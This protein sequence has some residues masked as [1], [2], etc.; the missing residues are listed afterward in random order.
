MFGIQSENDTYIGGFGEMSWFGRNELIDS[1]PDPV[2][3]NGGGP[4]AVKH[5]NEDHHDAMI[6]VA[7]AFSGLPSNDIDD[8]VVL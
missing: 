8:V 1:E 6:L 5:L 4:D 2:V 7:K 3:I